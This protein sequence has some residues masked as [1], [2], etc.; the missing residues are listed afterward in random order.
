MRKRAELAF[1]R[2]A[3]LVSMFRLLADWRSRW[4]LI[5]MKLGARA[6]GG[7][8]GG[9]VELR[10]KP[11]DGGPFLVR[12][13]TSDL[14][15]LIH[16]FV[17]GQHLPPP[18]TDKRPVTTVCELGAN[19]GSSVVAL[20]ALYP[21]ATVLGVEADPGNAAQA[22]RNV[23]GLGDRC[24]V[25]NAA[26]WDERAELVVGGSATDGFV[27]RAAGDGDPPDLP[28]V[29]GL[30]LDQVLDDHLEGRDIDFL[31]MCIEGSEP[32]ILGAGGTWP[33]RVRA[34]RIELYPDQGFDGPACV[35]LLTDLGYNAWFE[36][37]DRV[38]AGYGFA[39]R[40]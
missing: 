36:P 7:G 40:D 16:A 9:P 24:K 32:R 11:L 2:T 21:D 28:R 12:P 4:R 8:D 1:H 3:D 18:Q 17:Q 29:P 33:S 35:D 20:A 30:T 13:H 23:A 10:L 15:T 27:V 6:P 26:V 34:L 37:E 5:A 14:A 31:H 38:S 19:V 39:I 22:Q 25:V